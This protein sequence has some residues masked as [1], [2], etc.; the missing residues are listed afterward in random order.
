MTRKGLALLVQGLSGLACIAALWH[1]AGIVLAVTGM[2]L[3]AVLWQGVV[4]Y[5]VREVIVEIPAPLPP[6]C[7]PPEPLQAPEDPRLRGCLVALGDEIH[8][9]EQDMRFA[10]QLAREAGGKVN[11]SAE[12]IQVSADILGRLDSSMVQVASAFDELGAQSVQIGALVG[13]I[14]DISS[15]TN[16]LALNAAIEAARAGD[17]GRGFAVVADEVRTLAYRT[18]QSTQ[19]IEQM[20]GSV[21][22]GTEVAVSSMHA[23][24]ERARSA[25]D[26]TQASE[27]VLQ[28][29]YAAI[30]QIN[31]RNLVIASAAE[32]QAQVA[33]EVDRNLLNIRELSAQSAQGAEQ[34]SAASKT[35]S[36]LATELTALVGRFRV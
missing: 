35:L 18:Q 17:Q 8:A 2:A 16:L 5:R 36:G 4:E 9:T 29:I 23:S 32:E 14:Q 28:G 27:Q 30:G 25:L 13:S 26:T 12:S 7:P 3:A 19:E 31:E 15:Q 24:A 20:I 21:Q 33:R 10:N 6:P 22:H 34:T 1:P 11:A